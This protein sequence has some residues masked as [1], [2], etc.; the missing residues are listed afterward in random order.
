MDELVKT[1]RCDGT[2]MIYRDE[3][4]D[5]VVIHGQLEKEGI[6]NLNCAKAC[7]KILDALPKHSQIYAVVLLACEALNKPYL[8]FLIEKLH[9][10][11]GEQLPKLHKQDQEHEQDYKESSLCSDSSPE[12]PATA[13]GEE[14]AVVNGQTDRKT[15]VHR[16]GS[17]PVILSVPLIKRDGEFGV[18]QAD[19][20]AWQE[21]YQ[22]V[23]VM[24]ELRALRQ[25][26]IANAA[27]RKTRAGFKRHVVGWL[28]RAQNRSRSTPHP[29]PAMAKA[30]QDKR[31]QLG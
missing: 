5:L 10:R 16:S 13:F 3:T 1:V 27:H 28:G 17:S 21:D 23:D 15:S 7:E 12:L 6:I 25:W 26:N 18:T 22:G 4:T 24:V 9:E 20:D 14:V 2:P 30:D 29:S 8:K 19:V 31:R 11:L